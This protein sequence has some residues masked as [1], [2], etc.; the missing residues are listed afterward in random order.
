[1]KDSILV[2]GA[3]DPEMRRIEE[4]A[5]S[6]GIRTVHA[7][8]DHRRVHPGN[9]YRADPVELVDGDELVFIE[10]DTKQPYAVR[11]DHHRPGDPGYGLPADRYWEASSLGQ[12]YRWAF[13]PDAGPFDLREDKI[14]AAMDH[15]PA[16]A[17]RGE[18][19][20]VDPAE[21]LDRKVAEIAKATGCGEAGVRDE[22]DAA[23]RELS[24]SSEIVLVGD[25]QV[26][27]LRGVYRGVGYSLD[28]L[29]IQVAVLA[30][31]E[32]ALLRHRDVLGGPEKWSIAGHARPET[33]RAFMQDWA[34]AQGLTGVYGVPERGYAGGYVR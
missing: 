10:C 28:L 19:P 29:A 4:I 17:I 22:I 13:G 14:L 3:D 26:R 8:A 21:V 15:C 18:C 27:D 5:A 2:L 12:F 1:M 11:I 32:T 7:T 6:R 23:T 25:Q 20:G 30:A 16:A 34:P 33:I 24:W 9:A 31:G